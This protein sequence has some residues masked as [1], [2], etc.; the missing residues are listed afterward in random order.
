MKRSSNHTGLINLVHSEKRELRA[1]LQQLDEQIED[2]RRQRAEVA[3]EF[4]AFPADEDL[5]GMTHA[6][7]VVAVEP[8]IDAV[9]N[10]HLLTEDV[11]VCPG[12]SGPGVLTDDPQVLRCTK[13][14]GVFTDPKQPITPEQAIKFVRIQLPMATMR[15]F[16]RRT[17][18]YFDLD[19]VESAGAG[20]NSVTRVHGWANRE[21]KQVVQWG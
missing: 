8:L 3:E 20:L 13:C 4:Q 21:T 18:F 17:A 12:C 9:E 16:G 11:P 6:D 14:D 7:L 19:I 15:T 2:L 1:S 10:E 5:D